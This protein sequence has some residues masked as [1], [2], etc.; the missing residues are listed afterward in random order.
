L[1]K[2]ISNIQKLKRANKKPINYKFAP[3]KISW[4]HCSANQGELHLG[5]CVKE[6]HC[7]LEVRSVHYDYMNV[8][9]RRY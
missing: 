4:Q 7:G 1:S 5:K 9:I 6:I 3:Q 2:N 8:I